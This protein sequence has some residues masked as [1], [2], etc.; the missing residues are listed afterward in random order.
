VLAAIAVQYVIFV[1][2][3]IRVISV[4]AGYGSRVLIDHE[5]HPSKTIEQR[6][7]H[8]DRQ[9]NPFLP[10]DFVDIARRGECGVRKGFR[11]SDDPGPDEFVYCSSG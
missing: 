1:L 7:F 6:R 8:H 2:M 5:N 9:S 4:V 11:G 10:V 3:K